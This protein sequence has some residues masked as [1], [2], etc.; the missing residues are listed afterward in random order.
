MKETTGSLE[1]AQLISLC[2]FFWVF[3]RRQI[4]VGRCFRTLYQF[5]LQ[6]L[7]VHCTPSL[8]SWNWYRVP[9]RRPTTIWRRGNTQKK[10]HNIQITAKV[11]NQT[12][13][14]TAIVL[15]CTWPLLPAVFMKNKTSEFTGTL[16]PWSLSWKHFPFLKLKVSL[17]GWINGGGKK[18]V[19]EQLTQI[20]S[21]F[22]EC[23]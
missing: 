17:K 7:G 12:Y 10:I 23:W 4:V 15:Q 11:W 20:S 5:H 1:V 14:F 2:V 9:K 13:I 3:P 22:M 6:R 21:Y 19:L 16:Q 8:W 18:K